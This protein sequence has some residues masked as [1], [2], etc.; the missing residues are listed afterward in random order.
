RSR[1]RR[2]RRRARCASV[3]AL[4]ERHQAASKRRR[5]TSDRRPFTWYF[6]VGSFGGSRTSRVRSPAAGPR[7][8][9]LTILEQP[10][11]LVVARVFRALLVAAAIAAEP[12][13]A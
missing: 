9:A 1:S 13:T 8:A 7:N 12:D 5:C 2:E 6:V 10:L 11:H 3:D 4:D